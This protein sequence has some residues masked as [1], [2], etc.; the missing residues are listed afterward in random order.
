MRNFVNTTDLIGGELVSWEHPVTGKVYDF[1]V[2]AVNRRD[3]H[4]PVKIVLITKLE[5]DEEII[6]DSLVKLYEWV[7]E[8]WP[9]RDVEHLQ[10]SGY[11]PK[12]LSTA[13]TLDKLF[14]T[15]SQND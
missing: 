1:E 10:V 5:E 6:V 12:D 13:L 2:T 15:T 7:T 9:Y 4:Q 8:C 11:K 14:Y 3:E